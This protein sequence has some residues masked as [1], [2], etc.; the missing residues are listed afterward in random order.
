[1]DNKIIQ[2]KIQS[3]TVGDLVMESFITEVV[4]NE[5]KNKQY[6]TLYKDLIKKSVK[7]REDK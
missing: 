5:M 2:E 4:E 1:M 6:Y 3:K 7:Q